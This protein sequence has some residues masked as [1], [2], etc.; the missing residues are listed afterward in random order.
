MFLMSVS[1]KQPL[2][3]HFNWFELKDLRS[4]KVFG[5]RAAEAQCEVLL[6]YVLL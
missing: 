3:L 5:R 6:F 4:N 2:D 1:Y